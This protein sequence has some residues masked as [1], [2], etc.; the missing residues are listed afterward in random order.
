VLQ[1]RE[2]VVDSLVTIRMSPAH[3]AVTDKTN[4]EGLQVLHGDHFSEMAGIKTVEAKLADS[5]IL[6]VT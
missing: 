3:K 4:V 6:P 2:E 5:F 1:L